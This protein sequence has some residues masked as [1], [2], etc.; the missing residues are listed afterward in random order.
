M[1]EMLFRNC[2]PGSMDKDLIK[3]KIVI[4]NHDDGADDYSLNRKIDGVKGLGG[5]G[6]AFIDDQSRAV[7]YTYGAFPATV[8]TTKDAEEILS[9][10]NST[11]YARKQT[12]SYET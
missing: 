1:L 4:C 12:L 11:R 8:I 2:D 5:I 3:G 9:Y 10:I 7:A 6:I